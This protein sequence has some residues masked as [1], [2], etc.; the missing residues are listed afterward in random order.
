MAAALLADGKR[1]VRLIVPKPLLPQTAQILQ[2]RLG[3]LIGMETRHIPFSRQTPTTAE[4]M[5]S[6]QDL[7]MN[8]LTT[9]GVIL[10]SHEN[11]LSYKLSGLQRLADKKLD[12]AEHMISFQNWI[13]TNCRDVLDE[14]DFTLAVKTQLNYPSGSEMPV[15]GHPFRWQVIEELLSM[16]AHFV[17]DVQRR[18][19]RSIEILDRPGWFPMMQF[20]KPDVVDEIHNHLLA[21]IC[22]GRASF[23]RPTAPTSPAQQSAIREVLCRQHLDS[24]LYREVMTLY[25][26]SESAAKQ[27]LIVRGLITHKIIPTCLS[28]RWNIQYGLRAGGY[29]VAVPYE[30]RNT[31]SERA[32]WG[33]PDV[34][35][36]F[37][38]LSF[39]Y[40]GLDFAQFQ[41]GLQHVLTCEDPASQYERWI[42]QCESLPEDLRH[43]NVI[44][45]EDE[46]QSRDLWKHLHRT[47]A[48]VNHF[49]NTF[50]F[51]VHARQFSVKLQASAWDIPLPSSPAQ[52]GVKTTGFSGTNDS[53][54]PRTIKQDDLP[55]LKQTNAEVLSYLLQVR[56]RGYQLAADRYGRRLSEAGLLGELYNR[57]IRILIDAGAY[58]IEMDNKDLAR[59]WLEID[60]DAKAAVYFGEDNRA[61]VM[62]RDKSKESAPL[63]TTPFVNRL[64]ECVVYLDEAHTRGVDLK[65]HPFAA[66]VVTLSLK[67]TKDFTVQGEISSPIRFAEVTSTDN[68]SS[69]DATSTAEDDSKCCLLC[70][71]RG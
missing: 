71:P 46:E 23:L 3:G 32:E 55:H 25:P 51:P 70:P 52:R 33:H 68:G 27:L 10:T 49:L 30:S 67:Q 66:A 43:W 9:R 59:L 60:T 37:T 28:K 36:I 39:Y 20:L 48:V 2:S 29:P 47:Q 5:N 54:L 21:N 65:F 57:H 34:A 64:S 11:V 14:S 26:H 56:N 45:L 8:L 58:V 42:S 17:P 61:W 4:L 40:A 1:L 38:C 19:R 12:E 31:P 24:K 13:D 35:I 53:L 63:L 18:F 15:D 6:Y 41:Q 44:N 50:V 62:F 7:H 16:V 22:S 69:G